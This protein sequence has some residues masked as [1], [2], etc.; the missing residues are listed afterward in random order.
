MIPHFDTGQ[1]NTATDCAAA[2]ERV[3]APPSA[4]DPAINN[5]VATLRFGL[6]TTPSGDSRRGR[7]HCFVKPIE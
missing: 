2:G 3:A 6:Y 4:I 5:A 1:P 7:V